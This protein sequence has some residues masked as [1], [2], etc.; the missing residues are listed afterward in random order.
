MKKSFFV[1]AVAAQ[2]SA[3]F[4][5][6]PAQANEILDLLGGAPADSLVSMED[7]L[8][9]A[10]ETAA[11][12]ITEIELERE[13]GRLIYEVEVRTPK[14]REIELKYDARSGDLLSQSRGRK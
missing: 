3:F 9:R 5:L 11:G 10:R 4:F 8:A 12:T 7:I 13:G 2:L 6:T 1:I 14:G